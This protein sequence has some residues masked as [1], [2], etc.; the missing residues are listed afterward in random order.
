VAIAISPWLVAIYTIRRLS[1]DR[2]FLVSAQRFLKIASRVAI[3]HVCRR[4]YRAV[5]PCEFKRHRSE[6]AELLIAVDR[7]FWVR[8][9]R[10]K[11]RSLRERTLVISLSGDVQHTAPSCPAH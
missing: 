10:F 7:F 1:F 6:V 2:G 11:S 3:A 4:Q 5:N 8:S 9:N